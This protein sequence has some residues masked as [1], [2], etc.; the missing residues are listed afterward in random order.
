MAADAVAASPLFELKY[1]VRTFEAFANREDLEQAL[2]LWVMEDATATFRRTRPAD[3]AP[4]DGAVAAQLQAIQREKSDIEDRYGPV[5]IWDLSLLSDLSYLLPR[6]GLDISGWDVSGATSM[7]CMFQR[8]ENFN[9]DISAWNVCKVED[10]C[11]MFGHCKK[12]NQNLASW[13]VGNGA[14]FSH[15]F[16]AC[17]SFNQNLDSWDVAKAKQMGRMFFHCRAF[18]QS[19]ASW[20]VQGVKSF[21][22]MFEGCASLAQDFSS[23]NV[24]E[25]AT[26][27]DEFIS[28]LKKVH[29]YAHRGPGI[30]TF[31]KVNSKPRWRGDRVLSNGFE[32]SSS[33]C[34][35]TGSSL[36]RSC[37]ADHSMVGGDDLG[38]VVAA[39]AASLAGNGDA[40][41]GRAGFR[42]FACGKSESVAAHNQLKQR[43]SRAA[44]ELH[45]A[46]SHSLVAPHV[47]P[48]STT[49]LK[50]LAASFFENC[51]RYYPPQVLEVLRLFAEEVGYSDENLMRGAVGRLD[52]LLLMPTPRRIVQVAVSFSRARIPAQ[53][54]WASV[55][56]L[57]EDN[58]PHFAHGIPNLLEALLFVYGIGGSSGIKG[59]CRFAGVEAAPSEPTAPARSTP[60]GRAAAHQEDHAHAQEE[61]IMADEEPVFSKAK[62]EILV[63]ALA[64]QLLV[65]KD[66]LGVTVFAN[67]FERLSLFRYDYPEMVAEALRVLESSVAS[68]DR[69][70]QTN[71]VAGLQ[72]YGV[73][74]VLETRWTGAGAAAAG[75]GRGE[76]LNLAAGAACRDADFEDDFDG[77]DDAARQERDVRSVLTAGAVAGKAASAGAISLDLDFAV[78][79]GVVC[80]QEQMEGFL[81]D[82]E[83]LLQDPK[84][85]WRELPGKINQIAKLAVGQ[86]NDVEQ[87]RRNFVRQVLASTQVRELDLSARR[88]L[89]TLCCLQCRSGVQSSVP[90]GGNTSVSSAPW[91]KMMLT[92]VTRHGEPPPLPVYRDC[93]DKGGAEK[94][95]GQLE[96]PLSVAGELMYVGDEARMTKGKAP[97]VT[98]RVLQINGEQQS[99]EVFTNIE[100]HNRSLY[101]YAQPE[102]NVA[103]SSANGTDGEAVDTTDVADNNP[104]TSAPA[105]DM[106]QSTET[107][108]PEGSVIGNLHFTA[109]VSMYR[110][111]VQ[112]NV[113][114]SGVLTVISAESIVAGTITTGTSG[115]DL[116][117]SYSELQSGIAAGSG[118]IYLDHCKVGGIIFCDGV[119]VVIVE[120]G[121]GNAFNAHRDCVLLTEKEYDSSFLQRYAM[122]VFCLVS[123]VTFCALF[124]MASQ[125]A[126]EIVEEEGKG[127]FSSSI[128]GRGN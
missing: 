79:R 103:S 42:S 33:L 92:L 115:T 125:A 45:G 30:N 121:L 122:S 90:P 91:E 39:D 10:F 107:S 99:Y 27:P 66:K 102:E 117:C 12:F 58:F 57:V 82:T 53:H 75:R 51:D 87:L 88:T 114:G 1:Y 3:A 6:A 56:P 78:R 70:T 113:E 124:V 54:W 14:D 67:G 109:D 7:S 64:T 26:A 13:N 17:R 72:R 20:Q 52:D 123:M 104:V 126:N 36:R 21:A 55:C 5:R 80:G 128:V 93:L 29:A 112:G 76:H 16:E 62:C 25:T 46:S 47:V 97:A 23:W 86:D 61:E 15:M 108:F 74:D 77:V 127:V 100:R 37:E 105:P 83:K 96:K 38:R 120:M 32:S 9:N 98:T 69:I 34:P 24:D 18:D 81:N 22:A 8:C 95:N 65:Q 40:G 94:E 111:E 31:F 89:Y 63:D 49:L 68:G 119:D 73:R 48:Q 50:Q 4:L 84:F 101:W 35:T 118:T 60:T 44:G 106:V 59:G 43:P 11:G 85:V 28:L 2:A 71:L 41:E 116:Y 19:L 110:T